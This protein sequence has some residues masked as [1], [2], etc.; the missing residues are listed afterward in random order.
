MINLLTRRRAKG[1]AVEFDFNSSPEPKIVI[2]DMEKIRMDN[3][4][5]NQAFL[6]ELGLAELKEDIGLVQTVEEPLIRRKR[7]KKTYIERDQITPRKS[8]IVG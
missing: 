8:A 6:V 1:K 4:V 5:R 2:S 7:V 3:I